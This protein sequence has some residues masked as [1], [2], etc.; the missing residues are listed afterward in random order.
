MLSRLC[1]ISLV[2]AVASYLGLAAVNNLM[3]YSTNFAFVEH[4]MAMDNVFPDTPLRDRASTSTTVHQL[5]YAWIIAWEAA[6]ALL[7]GAGAGWLVYAL[8]RPAASFHRAKALAEA[9]LVFSLLLW[10]AAFLVVG[11]EWFVMWQ[12]KTWNGQNAAFR[13]FA[14]TALVL[15]YL[16]QPDPDLGMQGS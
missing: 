15:V 1:K 13:M 2:A 6:A 10:L 12:S 3:D 9:G 7:C 14:I 11:G 5:Y 16:K 4:V 8:R